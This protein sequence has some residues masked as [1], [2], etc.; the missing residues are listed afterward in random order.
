MNIVN[1]VIEGDYVI[2]TYDNGTVEKYL[3]FQNEIPEEESLSKRVSNEEI[4]E[5]QLIIMNALADI[6]EKI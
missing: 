2:N 5:N 6:Y 3:N 4:A 1:T